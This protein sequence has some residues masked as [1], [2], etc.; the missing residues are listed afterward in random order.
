MNLPLLLGLLALEPTP[1]AVPVSHHPVLVELFTSQGCSSCPAADAFVHELPRLGWNRDRVIPLTFHVDY[2]DDLGWKDPFASPAFTARQRQYAASG[3]LRSPAGESGLDGLYTPQMIVDGRVHFSG[4]RRDVALAEI[5]RAA[6]QRADWNLAVSVEASAR[7]VTVSARLLAV[8]GSPQSMKAPAGW[9]RSWSLFVALATPEERTQVA[10]GENAG[11]DLIEAEVVH[12]MSPPVSLVAAAP[13][14]QGRLRVTVA[15]P[16][17]LVGRAFDV[18][19]FVQ[20][21]DSGQ[22]IASALTSSK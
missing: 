16:A 2:W 15:R 6:A 8:G 3:R 9:L 11:R 19:A 14:A 10:R 4:G 22:V 21:T 1:A 5:A 13:D 18:V 17:E 12:A 7:D 20:A